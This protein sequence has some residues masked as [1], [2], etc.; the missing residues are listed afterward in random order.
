MISPFQT[1]EEGKVRF[2]KGIL[3]SP[4][5]AFNINPVKDED[6]GSLE[7]ECK[8]S[9]GDESI[10]FASEIHWPTLKISPHKNIDFIKNK[11]STKVKDVIIPP[12]ESKDDLKL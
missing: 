10:N 8:K 11:G 1:S 2:A 9:R 5:W 12:P 7:F 3:D 6:I 4:D